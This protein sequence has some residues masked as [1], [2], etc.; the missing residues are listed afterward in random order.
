MFISWYL[1]IMNMV[2]N[3]AFFNVAEVAFY[4]IYCCGYDN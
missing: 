3:C 2:V 1:V 4:F